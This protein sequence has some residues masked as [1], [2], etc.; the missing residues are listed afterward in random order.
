MEQ[1]EANGIWKSVGW[2]YQNLAQFTLDWELEHLSAEEQGEVF[3]LMKPLLEG[4]IPI[5]HFHDADMIVVGD[6]ER[7]F[8][9]MCRYADLG[10][11]ELICYVQFG[12]HSH[13]SAMRT[14]ELLGKEVIPALERYEPKRSK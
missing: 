9:K 11:D 4:D 5:Q 6:P 14:I 8:E 13:E 12:Y 1:A 10:V 3:P 7:C 2:W